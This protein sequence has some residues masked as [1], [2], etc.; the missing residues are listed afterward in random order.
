[1]FLLNFPDHRRDTRVDSTTRYQTN[2]C[3][4]KFKLNVFIDVAACVLCVETV[5]AVIFEQVHRPSIAHNM[6]KPLSNSAHFSLYNIYSEVHNFTT[7]ISD[8]QLI[9]LGRVCEFD[10]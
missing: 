9:P 4:S 2:G 1:M 10:N 3:M 8:F 7:Q 5:G 6:S